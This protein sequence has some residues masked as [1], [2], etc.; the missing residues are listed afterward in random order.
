MSQAT[1]FDDGQAD[2]SAQAEHRRT[3]PAAPSGR[4]ITSVLGRAPLVCE[5][6][7]STY[8]C[9]GRWSRLRVLLQ[10]TGARTLGDEGQARVEHNSRDK[11]E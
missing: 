6:I 9:G 5:S 3:Q 8:M 4:P 1:N 11:K 10:A 7:T 2:R